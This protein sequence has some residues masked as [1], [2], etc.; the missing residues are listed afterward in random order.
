MEYSKF[1]DKDLNMLQIIKSNKIVL[2]QSLVGSGGIV[3]T[4]KIIDKYLHEKKNILIIDPVIEMKE[5]SYYRLGGDYSIYKDNLILMNKDNSIKLLQELMKNPL[6]QNANIFINDIEFFWNRQSG[7]FEV[8]YHENELSKVFIEFLLFAKKN[9]YN[10]LM[11]ANTFEFLSY[12]RLTG[13]LVSEATI[14]EYSRF[15]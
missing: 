11:R 4:K 13:T 5:K 8:R 12:G 9:N 7:M 10:V 15:D 3:F 2:M 1:I 6:P 14:I